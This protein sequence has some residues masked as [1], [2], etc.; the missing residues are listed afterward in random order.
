MAFHFTIKE[1][2][3]QDTLRYIVNFINR[4]SADPFVIQFVQ[5]L[6]PGGDPKE[7]IKRLFD[8]I[9]ENGEYQLDQDGEEEVWTPAKT[10]RTRNANGKFQYDC[11]KI[12]ILIGSVLKA[13]GIE[14]VLKHVLY[15]DDKGGFEPYTH[16]YIIVP[17]P[18]LD[19]YLV[20]DPTNQR[21][22]N[23][24]V[25]YAEGNLYFL[26]GSQTPAPKMNLH[27]MGNSNRKGSYNPAV[28]AMFEGPANSMTADMDA[29]M[30]CPPSLVGAPYDPESTFYQSIGAW[31]PKDEK[32]SERVRHLGAV[33]AFW[34]QRAAF[35]ALV[36]LGKMTAKK[37]LRMHLAKRLLAAYKKN[38][39]AVRKWWWKVGGNPDATALKKAIM[40]GT[41]VTISGP[42]SYGKDFARTVGDGGAAEIAAL[43][44]AAG[45]LVVAV[46]SLFKQLGVKKGDQD[47]DTEG[48]TGGGVGPAP[49]VP[50]GYTIP[51]PGGGSVILPGGGGGG[52]QLKPGSFNFISDL[53]YGNITNALIKSVIVT[54]AM[55]MHFPR[56]LHFIQN[57]LP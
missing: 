32:K 57:L 54:T 20:V 11:K 16:I 12:T 39:D 1:A 15:S 56:I 48:E 36:R 31:S 35:L 37:P 18:D 5:E 45:T 17:D 41:G 34:S 4:Y 10:I 55:Q 23:K 13:A 53:C 22:W 43:I 27:L 50:G 51:I 46:T 47:I 25:D 3:I 38:P 52:P 30:G 19:N 24:E 8:Y 7:F 28:L 49:D 9:C 44:A 2:S 21:R 33:N 40:K 6:N 29:T 26:D 42:Y 14:P